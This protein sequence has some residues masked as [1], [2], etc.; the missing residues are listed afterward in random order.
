MLASMSF[1]THANVLSSSSRLRHPEGRAGFIRPS[2]SDS[3][4]KDGSFV[5]VVVTSWQVMCGRWDDASY[6]ARRCPSQEFHRRFVVHGVDRV[7]R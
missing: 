7:W 6:K 3:D 4:C 5:E 1:S 2:H